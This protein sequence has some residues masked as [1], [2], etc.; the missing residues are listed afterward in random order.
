MSTIDDANKCLAAFTTSRIEVR[1]GGAYVLWPKYRGEGEE[2]RRWQCRGQ[3]FYPT[4]HQQWP[5]GGTA[6]TA[7]A[8]LIRWVQGKPVL[9]IGTWYYWAG[10]NV[11]LL[12][13]SVV[14]ELKAN[15]YPE[16]A[17]C[18]LCHHRIDGGMDWWSLNGVTGPCCGW[19]SGCRQD[20]DFVKR[21]EC[22]AICRT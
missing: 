11:K 18:V 17:D 19:K 6:S 1:R 21:Q 20:P 16:Y 2:C 3:D 8:Q 12:T 10:N 9:P 4:W 13:R 22:E 15:G 14:D 5:G 7:L